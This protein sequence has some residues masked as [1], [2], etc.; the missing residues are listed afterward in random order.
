[1]MAALPAACSANLDRYTWPDGAGNRI[2]SWDLARFVNHSCD[3]NCLA[4][5]LGC[6]LAIRDIEAGEE[7]TNDY[8]NLGM[9]PDEGFPCLC[10]SPHCRGFISGS[11]E[12]E[13]Q[14][15]W[16]ARV[17]AAVVHVPRVPQPLW[18]LLG[19]ELQEHLQA[20]GAS[21]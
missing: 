14:G 17:A 4:G 9:Q 16:A 2:L 19:N 3:P 11:V 21:I 18:T 10:G 6:E 1:M 8:A 13:L 5:P 20:V 12:P 7:L 15:V